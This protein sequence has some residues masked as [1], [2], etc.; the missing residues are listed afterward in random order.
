M[1]IT[2]ALTH[3]R[4][5]KFVIRFICG[6]QS[7]WTHSSVE[8][9]WFIDKI[10]IKQ[11]FT[12]YVFHHV[13]YRI[14]TYRLGVTIV[15]LMRPNIYPDSIKYHTP[16]LITTLTAS[17]AV[18]TT[19]MNLPIAILLCVR[20]TPFI[21]EPMLMIPSMNSMNVLSTWNS[22]QI[23]FNHFPALF[24]LS[25]KNAAT[26]IYNKTKNWVSL[27]G[28]DKQMIDKIVISHSSFKWW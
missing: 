23:E 27:S 15:K 18:A 25:K 5:I 1:F 8:F 22:I 21:F 6:I 28:T 14:A 9:T 11:K 19:V 24:L 4:Y 20:W 10:I 26:S 17:T 3:N 7:K 16:F 13:S 2:L 12:C